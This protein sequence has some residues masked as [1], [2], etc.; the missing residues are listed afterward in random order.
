MSSI[1]PASSGRFI[2][3]DCL[4]QDVLAEAWMEKADNVE[5]D[6][7]ADDR[8]ELDLHLGKGDGTRNLPRV[9]LDQHV[10]IARPIEIFSRYG[11]EEGKPCDPVPAARA[12]DH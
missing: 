6:C 5:V 3:N 12:R 4:F 10:D 11:P 9:E 7:T 8:G 2:E 1:Q